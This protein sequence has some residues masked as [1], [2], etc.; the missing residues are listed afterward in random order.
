MRGTLTEQPWEAR[1]GFKSRTGVWSFAFHKS[2]MTAGAD[3]QRSQGGA[4]ARPMGGLC[5]PHQCWWSGQR[6]AGGAV[7]EKAFTMRTPR[8]LARWWPV[9]PFLGERDHMAFRALGCGIQASVSST[10]AEMPQRERQCSVNCTAG[11]G[12][13]TRGAWCVK[14]SLRQEKPR[15]GTEMP[16]ASPVGPSLSYISSL[17]P[18]PVIL[19]R[20]CIFMDT[21]ADM[22]RGSYPGF[23]KVT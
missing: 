11:S 3:G 14:E 8:V 10:A 18:S 2:S 1:R 4:H 13:P 7:S 16:P 6:G 22:P 23:S 19:T 12:L 20:E 5:C 15:K 9:V 21:E 17:P